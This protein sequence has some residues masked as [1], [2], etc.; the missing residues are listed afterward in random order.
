VTV[1][2]EKDGTATNKTVHFRYDEASLSDAEVSLDGMNWFN[3]AILHKAIG[4]FVDRYPLEF[5]E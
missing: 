2:V 5:S 3:V 4:A 1:Q